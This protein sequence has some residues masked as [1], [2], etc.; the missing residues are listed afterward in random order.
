MAIMEKDFGKEVEVVLDN[1]NPAIEKD[2]LQGVF[3]KWEQLGLY[4][5]I[6]IRMAEF[7]NLTYI[8][9]RVIRAIHIYPRG[10]KVEDGP[11]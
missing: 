9:E 5:Y 1:S 10:G 7:K 4:N 6:V 11:Q 2:S 8:S 3:Q